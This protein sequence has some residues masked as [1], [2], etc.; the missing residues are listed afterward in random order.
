MR[1][2]RYA[3]V[4]GGGTGGHVVPALAVAL[5]LRDRGHQSTEIEF[6]GSSRGEGSELMSGAGFG[7]TLLPG[8]GLS[9]RLRPADV[10]RNL[11]ALGALAWA[12]GRAV[13]AFGRWR[14]RVVVTVGGFASFPAGVAAVAWR[15]PMVVVNIDAVPGLVNRTLGRFAAACAVGL[16]GTPLPRAVVTGTPVRADM[17]TVSRAPADRAAARRRLG[18]PD[19]PTLAVFGGSLGARRLNEAALVL[20]ERWAGRDDRVLYHVAGRRDYEM[21]RA[22]AA[23]DV[24]HLVPFERDMPALYAAADLVVCRAGA[25]TVAELALAGVPAVLVP[26]PGAPGDHQSA[27]ARA[28]LAAGAAVVLPDAECQG[29]R[30]A[31]L[32]DG[33]L[34]DPATLAAMGGAARG[35]GRADAAAAV[36]EVAAGVARADAR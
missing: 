11:A 25:M 23:A 34:D 27:N 26:L 7:V 14:P 29:D 10:A 13:A 4:S 20:A 31:E 24:H 2:R 3:V 19:R 5:A 32:A 22:R 35:L 21:V 6:V 28:L 15:V 36:A 9:R 12:C 1:A 30:L 33:L 16:P 8:R 18:L 17:A